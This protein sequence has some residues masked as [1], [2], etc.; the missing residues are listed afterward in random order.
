MYASSFKAFV[1]DQFNR[2]AELLKFW[3]NVKILDI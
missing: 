1:V 2:L 3:Q